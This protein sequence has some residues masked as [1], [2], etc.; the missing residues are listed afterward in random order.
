MIANGTVCLRWPAYKSESGTF[1]RG[2][3]R[4]RR[5]REN[6]GGISAVAVKRLIQGTDS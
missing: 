3:Q 4:R 1:G 5:L 6:I 2:D